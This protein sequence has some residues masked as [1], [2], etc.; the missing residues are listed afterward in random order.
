MSARATC[1]CGWSG[2]YATSAHAEVMAARHVCKRADGVR[3]A[4]RRFRCGRCGLESVYENAGATEARYWFDKHSCQRRERLMLRAAQAEA[5]RAL[6]DRTP[7]PCHHKQTT[8]EHGTPAC[9]VLDRCRCIPCM[10]ANTKRE[11][12]RQRLKA[13]GRYNKYVPAE[14]VRDHLAELKDYGIGLKTVA[15]LSGVGNGTL[16]KIWYGT[17]ATTGRG[18]EY[19]HGTGEFLRGPS[20]RVLRKTAEAIYAVEAVPANL[21]PRVSDHERTPL[22]RTHLRALVALGWSMNQLGTRLGMKHGNNAHLIITGDRVLAR[23]TVDRAEALFRELAMTPPPESNQR[24]RISA[25]RARK[26][27][28]LEG[29]PPPLALEDLDQHEDLVVDLVD[30]VDVDEVAIQRRMNGD[31]TVALS[32][33]ENVELVRR[34]RASGRPMNECARVTGLKPERYR[35]DA[36]VQDDTHVHQEAS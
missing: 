33:A 17:Y 11:S 2:A 18:K 35:V 16:T 8:H 21:G 6:I 7:Q 4:T 26:Y 30:L 24:E 13:Y 14:F 23:E 5:Q 25:S 28:R 15:K 1:G 9:Y 22:A 12:E 3:R 19:A 29:W 36:E 10:T 20:R 32:T 27:A 31:R 34:W